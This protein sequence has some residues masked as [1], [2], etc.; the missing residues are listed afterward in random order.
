MP[1]EAVL[2]QLRR[3]DIKIT[4]DMI[5]SLSRLDRAATAEL[6]AAWPTLPLDR[7]QAIVVEAG[8]T[9]EDDVEVDFDDLFKV[10]LR[11][12][13][14]T[15]KV[16][17]IQGLWEYTTRD[18]ITP[19]IDLL[20]KDSDPGVRSTAAL[21]LGRF[22]LMGEFD[23]LPASEQDRAEEALRR[24]Y[25]RDGEDLEVRA[26]ALESIGASS[27]PYVGELIGAAH[28][29]GNYRLRLSAIHAMGRSCDERWLPVLLQEMTD[30]EAEVRFEAVGATGRIADESTINTIAELL[31]DEDRE[32]QLAAIEALGHIGGRR[33]KQHLRLMLKSEEPA[34]REAAETALDEADLNI[35][36]L[37]AEYRI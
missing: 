24:V 23:E 9:A 34:L 33:V 4:R 7:R 10:A 5:Y 20:E 29:S 36:P 28:Q 1:L 31:E 35:D 17:A 12:D 18:L 21:A 15:V 8:D 32:V 13:D 14:S 6:R 2:E 11:D 22:V 16:A 30:D 25:D 37:T 19:L 3:Q 26:R 27:K